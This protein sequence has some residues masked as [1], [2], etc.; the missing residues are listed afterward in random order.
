MVV[1]HHL[2]RGEAL[3]VMEKP[4]HQFGGVARTYHEAR[5]PIP[6]TVV[7]WLTEG[8]YDEVLDLAAGTGKLTTHLVERELR[9][10]AVE[11]DPRMLTVLRRGCPG[12]RTAVG[13]ASHI[14]L[15]D[16]SVDAVFVARSWHWFE[17]ESALAEIARV[18][19][20]GGRLGVV[21]TSRDRDV[22]WVL[23]LDEIV[24][25]QHEP[26]RRPGEF[27]LPA[28]APFSEPEKHVITWH[29]Q[30]SP[31][32]L[33]LSLGTYSHVLALPP[34]ERTMVLAGA[35]RYL[36][37]NPELADQDPINVPIRTVCFRTR[38][39]AA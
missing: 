14:P 6:K 21:W 36:A 32:D 24:R 1:R 13:S 18:L 31:D 12:A 10:H 37:D 7:D 3:I 22:P 5:P 16:N 30:V 8:D 38:L 4:S 27:T 25:Y 28:G 33:V 9:V 39:L 35:Q 29:W 11:A 19:R 2:D 15:A 20:P 26:G 34:K 17:H 23:E